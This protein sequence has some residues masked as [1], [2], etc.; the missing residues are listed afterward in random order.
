LIPEAKQSLVALVP[1]IPT[2]VEAGI[3]AIIQ[4]YLTSI[5]RYYVPGPV[6]NAKDKE[7]K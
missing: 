1:T 3:E 4:A 7:F 5:S 2:P 6:L